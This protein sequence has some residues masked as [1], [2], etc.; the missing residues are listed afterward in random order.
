MTLMSYGLYRRFRESKIMPA[1]MTSYLWAGRTGE[2]GK[3][4]SENWS[5]G[6]EKEIVG[7]DEGSYVESGMFG[8][9]GFSAGKKFSDSVSGEFEGSIKGSTGTRYDEESIKGAKGALGAK[10]QRSASAVRSDAQKGLGSEVRTMQF[11]FSG[12][13]GPFSGTITFILHWAK[14]DASGEYENDS[15]EFEFSAKASIPTAGADELET[16]IAAWTTEGVKTLVDKARAYVASKKATAEAGADAEKIDAA[17][18]AN[19]RRKIGEGFTTLFDGLDQLGN[20]DGIK[21]FFNPAAEPS[22]GWLDAGYG[23]E[24]ISDA[25]GQHAE[26]LT[27]LT[28]SDHLAGG[29]RASG[30]DLGH[31]VGGRTMT[32]TIGLELAIGAAYDK[33]KHE[34]EVQISVNMVKE[35]EFAIPLFLDISHSKSTRFIAF[36]KKTGKPW[37]IL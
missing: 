13:V 4:K 1:G 3:Y 29:D 31:A 30:E 9:V 24:S 22:G 6:V 5:R 28:G 33:G 7:K 37:E 25:G 34:W 20:N 23:S 8:G 18:K 21:T 36:R 16:K 35:K 2:F 27:K 12:G 19:K 11:E 17:K 14:D 26:N 32:S 10:N 15:I